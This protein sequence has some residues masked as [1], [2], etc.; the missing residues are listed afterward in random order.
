MV[1]ASRRITTSKLAARPPDCR[2]SDLRQRQYR[3]LARRDSARRFSDRSPSR[4]FSRG[5]TVK[6]R[7]STVPAALLETLHR[8][9]FSIP[10]RSSER[11][12]YAKPESRALR[13]FFCT[14]AIFFPHVRVTARLRSL[15]TTFLLANPSAASRRCCAS[16]IRRQKMQ[17]IRPGRE[18]ARGEGADIGHQTPQ[19][20]RGPSGVYLPIDHKSTNPRR[21]LMS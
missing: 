9:R 20:P 18:R 12:R 11:F 15:R 13:L 4:G 7:C 6:H 8:D 19:A 1:S 3:Q 17:P 16:L 21:Y 14:T 10:A 2:S 5:Q